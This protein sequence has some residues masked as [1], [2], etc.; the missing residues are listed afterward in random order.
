M[1][2]F[3]KTT[4]L[5]GG[6]A[7][8]G[9][10][11]N[12]DAIDGAS[13]AAGD[14]AL[15]YVA[16]RARQYLL[17]ESVGAVENSPW[18][19][20]PDSN[21][22]NLWWDLHNVGEE[23]IKYLYADY[24]GSLSAALTDIGATE[25]IL[26]LDVDNTVSADLASPTTLTLRGVKGCITTLAD[27]V[28]LTVNGI[29]NL[30][31][32]G[33]F[34]GTAGGGTETLVITGGVV[35][36]PGQYWIGANLVT[37]FSGYPDT[38]LYAG[39]WVGIGD[40][41]DVSTE[42]QSMI[43]SVGTSTNRIFDFSASGVLGYGIGTVLTLPDPGAGSTPRLDWIFRNGKLVSTAA[44]PIFN[45]YSQVQHPAN[46][47][48]GLEFTNLYL[49]GGGT[50][51]NGLALYGVAQSMTIKELK[52][53]GFTNAGLYLIRCLE[54]SID[55]VN[56]WDN[57]EYQAYVADGTTMNFKGGA[58]WGG[59]V[60]IHFD[61]NL[62]EALADVNSGPFGVTLIDVVTEANSLHGIH[63]AAGGRYSFVR[64]HIE[65]IGYPSPDAGAVGLKIS[66]EGGEI[67]RGILFDR[68]SF[69]TEAGIPAFD[70]SNCI[71]VEFLRCKDGGLKGG[72]IAATAYYTYITSGQM[73]NDFRPVTA[74]NI[75]NNSTTTIFE[76]FDNYNGWMADEDNY[77]RIVDND[78]I[79]VVRGGAN[80]V[81]RV[82]QSTGGTLDA[83][84]TFNLTGDGVM[85]FGAGGA[86]A[87]DVTLSRTAAN[88]LSLGAGDGLGV[89][90][91]TSNA[92]T[93]SG[94]TSKAWP[95]YNS[96]GV[97]L[98][99]VPIYAA[100]W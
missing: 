21:P 37:D 34:D 61:G 78:Y 73:S 92:N 97:L 75:T 90:N 15:T 10:T 22:G 51:T 62:T 93:P 94:A 52:V 57:T 82:H 58:Y 4:G 68:S 7:W 66:N 11:G 100:E 89:G 27:G 20:I 32:G 81:L 76:F 59:K 63:V 16:G 47:T 24:A 36:S 45:T 13:L 48:R 50:G 74:S 88:V 2:T 95:I 31:E 41:T 23:G 54:T 69:A 18:V 79:Q 6:G 42:L 86:T 46:W 53:T 26:A 43:D 25:T 1:A 30:S 39:W 12:L 49:D 65:S 67:P 33:Y 87:V 38:V 9:G 96:S 77:I 64:H 3:Y 29:L 14:V 40:G 80:I 71:N 72:T 5:I 28:T 91:T 60:G 83:Q 56:S 19:I 84:P 44:V 85:S 35:A 99:Y 98:G 70:L 17:K 55:N 8:S